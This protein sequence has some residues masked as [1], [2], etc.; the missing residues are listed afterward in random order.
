[1]T[2]V[3]ELFERRA[4]QHPEAPAVEF[5]ERRLTY[6]QLDEAAN[7]LA[8]HLRG[9]GTKPGVRVGICLE[10]SADVAISVLAVLKAGGVYVPLDPEYPPER[11]AYMADDAGVSVVV[12][13]ERNRELVVRERVVDLDR[14]RREIDGHSPARLHATAS[15]EA[16]AFVLYTSGSTGRPK[17]V[18]TAHRSV[19]R[20]VCD[21]NYL[22][23]EPG[24][25][26]AQGS[27]CSFDPLTFEL[28]GPLL[29]GGSVVVL[30]KE[31]MVDP[32]ALAAVL[33]R[34]GIA[35]MFMTTSAFYAVVR[36][37][38][39]TFASLRELIVGGE[40]LEAARVRELAPPPGRL[41]NVYG[42]T[43]TTTFAT[44]FDLTGP[45]EDDGIL[46]IGTPVA[47]TETYVLDERGEPVAPG[48]VGE[49]Y[50][51]G[52]GVGVGYLGR[53]VL[54][55]EKFVPHPFTERA[56][57]RLYRTGDHV[58]RRPD[59]VLE[60]VR[61]IDGQVKIR[62]FRIEIGEVEARLKE[63]PAVRTAA[64][65]V[66]EFQGGR[67][68]VAYVVPE[69][70]QRTAAV[71]LRAF[72]HQSLPGYMVPSDFVTLDALPLSANGKVDRAALRAAPV[73]EVAAE[74]GASATPVEEVLTEVFADVLEVPRVRP[75]D[76]FFALG[77]DSLRATRLVARA[78]ELLGSRIL[79]RDLL[80]GPNPR[81]L[82]THVGDDA[83]TAP[84]PR[85]RPEL[86]PLSFAQQRLWFMDQVEPGTSRYNVPITLS[87]K[88]KLDRLALADALDEVVARHE[89]L[90]TTFP[91]PKGR[92]RQVVADELHVDLNWTDLSDDPGEA[93][94][95][96]I[97]DGNAPFDLATG[98]LVRAR[99]IR[100]GEDEH[101]LLLVFH[102]IVIDAWSLDI[103]LRE[104]GELYSGK[105]L[106]PVTLQ[107]ADH[108]IW[109]REWLRGEV[110][111]D[112]LRYWRAALG[113][114]VPTLDLPYD[115][116][117][118]REGFRGATA[119]RG[120][121]AAL[122][123]ELR[124]LSRRHGVTLYMTLLAA[125]QRQLGRWAGADEVVVG[126][127]IAGRTA[128][129]LRS[130]V[131]CLI[132]MVPVRANLATA[133]DFAS[134][135][136]NVR[137]DT[138]GAFAHQ[139]LPFDRLVEELGPRRRPRDFMPLFRVMFSF[140]DARE[141]PEFPGVEVGY[142]LGWPQNAA[143]FA[144]S[145]VVEVAG[146][147]LKTTLQYDSDRFT[148]ETA[149]A[150]LDGFER[151]LRGVTEEDSR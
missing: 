81:A 54:T 33:R 117:G 150:V 1:M 101:R 48:E 100:L 15:A 137:A 8:H 121:D 75:D 119:V 42:P 86:V 148:P 146:P 45:P 131:G 69:P 72:L 55:A 135:L 17:G 79:L 139:D 78:N 27:S 53:P 126:T 89:A 74:P 7:R 10:R 127:P 108:A 107:C 143:Q 80:S 123:R 93:A 84:G 29:N 56:G 130:V 44:W 147:E 70:G 114:E 39:D 6:R 105:S 57:A 32:D 96:T 99:L 134:L 20:L 52:A 73:P 87:L 38:P 103:V 109:Q 133:P 141:L 106:A 2:G 97:E 22:R 115:K 129:E 35:V 102:H 30:A 92:P 47:G 140:L 28:W 83:G 110:L 37:R 71:D 120:I 25:R 64:V 111:D 118:S 41:I 90:R 77:G 50:I 104:L 144:L 95:L 125:F 14:D 63:H 51:G 36:A 116:P 76:D 122:V 142:R 59:G 4:D 138:L 13:N 46:P 124:A 128:P 67:R 91:S 58:R 132:N 68:L 145:L 60:F 88:G 151:T 113:T 5:G 136:S 16:P 85:P 26:V 11:L 61:R 65:V 9:L 49:L 18:L 43:E 66:A 98:P 23:V 40:A 62:G 82:A 112:L 31:V 3:H 94:R 21:T 34:T 12:T 149:M 19:V 24:D